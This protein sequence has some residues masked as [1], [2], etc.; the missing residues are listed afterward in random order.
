MGVVDIEEL[1]WDT[2]CARHFAS[3]ILLV[4]RFEPT[5]W[6]LRVLSCQFE[7]GA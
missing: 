2:D 3:V 5:V 6:R 7:E 1:D 4:F